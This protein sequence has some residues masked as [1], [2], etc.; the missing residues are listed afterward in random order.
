MPDTFSVDVRVD[1]LP[2]P[3]LLLLDARIRTDVAGYGDELKNAMTDAI[4]AAER[5]IKDEIPRGETGE[6]GQS[7]HVEVG[8]IA[9]APGGAGGG[10][11]YTTKISVGAGVPQFQFTFEGTGR[12]H[13]SPS[14]LP[15]PRGNIVPLHGHFMKFWSEDAE[16]FVYVAETEGQEPQREWYYAATTFINV[17]LNERLSHIAS[18]V[19]ATRS[20][21]AARRA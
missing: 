11:H 4:L 5:I 1:D 20:S 10:G 12:F 19:N 14:G 7:I 18:A 21:R 9:Y 13:V 6:L 3:G 2:D 17:F 8:G 16:D 15:E